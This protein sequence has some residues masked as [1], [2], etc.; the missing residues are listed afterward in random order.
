MSRYTHFPRALA[1]GLNLTALGGEEQLKFTA[2][3]P[4]LDTIAVADLATQFF[5]VLCGR[6]QSYIVSLFLDCPPNIPGLPC[7]SPA[8]VA[9]F[10][11]AGKP[12]SC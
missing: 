5:F 10:T 8:E 3:A 7:P 1:L 6:V 9:N 12:G 2:Q 4:V 11:Q